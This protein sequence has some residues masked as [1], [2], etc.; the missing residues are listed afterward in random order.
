MARRQ[1]AAASSRVSRQAVLIVGGFLL[2]FAIA[3]LISSAASSRS[4]P[5]VGDADYALMV[6]DLFDHE[7]SVFNARERLLQVSK[8]PL[9]MAEAA[10]ER[11][12]R[13]RPEARREID[14]LRQL[15][16]AL[17]QAENEPGVQRGSSGPGVV[18]LA[19]LILA[20]VFLAAGAAWIWKQLE[21]RGARVRLPGGAS[22]RFDA[23]P[24]IAAGRR[25]LAAAFT[26]VG[27]DR[28]RGRAAAAEPDD[29]VD[30]AP[31]PPPR[32]PRTRAGR[33]EADA[34]APSRFARPST[35]RETFEARYELGD[36]EFDHVHPIHGSDGELIGACGLS[37][38]EPSGDRPG[39]FYGFTAWLQGYGSD[40]EL[41]ALGLVTR[42]GQ[43]AR[44]AAIAE[45]E[46]RGTV[47]E[48][49]SV[50]RGRQLELTTASM[51][52]RVTIVDFDYAA[53][54]P[55]SPGYFGRLIVRYEVDRR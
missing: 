30:D 8:N 3:A 14:S 54:S 23:T 40:R 16:Q 37:A 46:R 20:S 19:A 47:D 25:G 35:S 4:A 15:A 43:L 32:P 5:R 18:G 36:E 28:R 41:S 7:K 38:T 9:D 55:G 11:V 12:Q 45:W 24:F 49:E 27:G 42:T 39:R 1:L 13:D 2:G 22:P 44:S 6:A 10:L 34:R 21:T 50:D 33:V 51:R 17:R 31:P 29:E 52:A 53:P 26:Q 48:V